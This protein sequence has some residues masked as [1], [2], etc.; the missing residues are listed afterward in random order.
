MSFVDGRW[1]SPDLYYCSERGASFIIF[2]R[3]T[4]TLTITCS[5]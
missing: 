5:R 3:S 1:L 4:P 2:N